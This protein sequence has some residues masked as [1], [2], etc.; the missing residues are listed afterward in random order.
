MPEGATNGYARSSDVLTAIDLVLSEVRGLRSEVADWRIEDQAVVAR[1]RA[2]FE[3]CRHLSLER[4]QA[5]ELAAKR[6]EGQWSLAWGLWSAVRS[7]WRALGMALAW[8]VT[9]VVAVWR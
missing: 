9:A 2:D 7:N 3:Q 4:R 6:R 5:D 8:A 1:L